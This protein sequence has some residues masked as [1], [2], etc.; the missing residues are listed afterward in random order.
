[1]TEIRNSVREARSSRRT[2]CHS[3]NVWVIEYWN[4]RFIWNL[5]LVIWDFNN[6]RYEKEEL[7]N[8]SELYKSNIGRLT[9]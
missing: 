3:S 6:F 2:P 4:L 1:M 7:L 5:V 9:R 8:H